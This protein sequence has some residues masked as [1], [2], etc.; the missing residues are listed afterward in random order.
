MN[1]DLLSSQWQQQAPALPPQS[2][3]DALRTLLTGR[4]QTPVA[5]MRRNVWR[6]IGGTAVFVLLLAV[7]GLRLG[8]LPHLGVLLPVVVLYGTLAYLHWRTL[9]VLRE[10]RGATNTLG[11]HIAGQ[12]RQLR[13]LMRLYHASTMLTTL[14]LVGLVSYVTIWQVLPRISPAATGRFLTW[15]VLTAA[16]TYGITHWISRYHLQQAY[17]QHLDRL[18][19]VLHELHDE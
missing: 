10:L 8:Y 16:V 18:E 1:I 19:T 9:R 2:G 3:P 11:G 12:L 4:A 14:V 6:E 7:V 13:Q 17:G 5:Q 15:Y